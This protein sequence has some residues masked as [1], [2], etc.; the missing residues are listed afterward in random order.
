MASAELLEERP[1]EL[2]IVLIRSSSGHVHGHSVDRA[3][4]FVTWPVSIRSSSGQVCGPIDGAPAI[5][6]HFG[7]DSLRHV[8]AD[9]LDDY[10]EQKRTE[11]V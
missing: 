7:N 2:A 9:W 11:F 4:A 3:E 5:I 10:G 6:E 1:V 8:D